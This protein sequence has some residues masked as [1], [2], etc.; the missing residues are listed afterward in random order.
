MASKDIISQEDVDR[1]LNEKLLPYIVWQYYRT[2]KVNVTLR[3]FL[4][5]VIAA[6]KKGNKQKEV[7]H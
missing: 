7:R 6:V 1:Y 5:D 3:D 2:S 4:K